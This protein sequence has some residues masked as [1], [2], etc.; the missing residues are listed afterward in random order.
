MTITISHGLFTN[1]F[2]K[3]MQNNHH[4]N[5]AQEILILG[6]VKLFWEHN[7]NVAYLNSAM[8]YA[9]GRRGIR[10]NAVRAFLMHFTGAVYK[11]GKDFTKAGKKVKEMPEGFDLLTSWLGWANEHAKEPEYDLAKQQLK[12]ISMLQ[13]EKKLAEENNQGVMVSML[14]NTIEDYATAQ[15][16]ALMA[17]EAVA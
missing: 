15:K 8:Q 13:R 16:E 9:R 6:A 14:S 17:I 5:K 3:E 10:V 12:V 1:T 11:Q 7:K 4:A 2:N